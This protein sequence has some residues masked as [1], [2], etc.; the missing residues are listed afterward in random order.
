MLED[1][2]GFPS[3][4]NYVSSRIL[5]AVLSELAYSFIFN[6]HVPYSNGSGSPCRVANPVVQI[7]LEEPQEQSK[8]NEQNQNP[9]QGR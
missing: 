1:V 3:C 2:F 4:Q 7:R 6:F 9:A 5:I 8:E